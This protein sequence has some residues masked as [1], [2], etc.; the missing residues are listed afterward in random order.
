MGALFQVQEE[1]RSSKFRRLLAPWG[2][3]SKAYEG[4]ATPPFQYRN[5]LKDNVNLARKANEIIAEFEL[6]A[7]RLSK[8]SM[9]AV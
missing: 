3:K 8:Y 9:K 5:C 6:I 1:E 2:M 4:I 7:M